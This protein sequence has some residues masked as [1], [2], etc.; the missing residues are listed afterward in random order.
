MIIQFLFPLAVTLMYIMPIHRMIMRI[1]SEKYSKIREVMRMMGLSDTIYWLSWF[2]FYT[3]IVTIIS[4]ASTAIICSKVFP[5]SNWGLILL[6]FWL[7]GMSLFGYIIFIQSLFSVP[8]TASIMSILIYFFTSFLDFTVNSSYL[9]EYR[10]ILASILPTIGMARAIS[11]IS[12]YEKAGIGLQTSNIFEVYRN[13]SVFTAYY[14]FIV[15]C[16]LSY[17]TGIYLTNVLP[18]TSVGLRRKWYYPFTKSYWC[19]VKHKTG[20]LSR[21]K[22]RIGVVHDLSYD[23]NDDS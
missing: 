9:E 2:I 20:S 16:V 14:M 13:Y 6:F 1:V 7:Y 10:K 21:K 22:S 18:S 15:G 8:R 4:I 17:L 19:G 23:I 12:K 5:H 11:N 3:I